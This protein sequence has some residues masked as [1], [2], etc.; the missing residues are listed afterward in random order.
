MSQYPGPGFTT[1][2]LTPRVTQA[3]EEVRN[4]AQ[5]QQLTCLRSH[6]LLV[7]EP[8]IVG[9]RQDV[10]E[11]TEGKEGESGE[12]QKVSVFELNSR[13]RKETPEEALSLLWQ[14]HEQWCGSMT[15]RWQP[16]Q[17]G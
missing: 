11:K 16:L 5:R 7:A 13:G 10:V 4:E 1:S 17:G 15:P 6:G 8:S 9:E 3:G 14:G 12:G 2:H